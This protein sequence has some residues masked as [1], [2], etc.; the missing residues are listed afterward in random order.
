MSADNGIYILVTTDMHK[1]VN[2]RTT[3]NMRPNGVKAYR[4]AHAQAI[5]NLYYYEKIQK[6]NLGWC[7]DRIFGN[8]PTFYNEDEAYDYAKAL[9]LD[10]G[11]TE[12]GICERDFSRYAYP[13]C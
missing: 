13:G 3:H 2:D 7:M 9:E 5:D 11:Y 10:I 12:Y 1:W 6:Y 4:V 8:S